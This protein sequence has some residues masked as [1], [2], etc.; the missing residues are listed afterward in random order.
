[1]ND[2]ATLPQTGPALLDAITTGMNPV[3]A[4][5]R[6]DDV[7]EHA[8]IEHADRACAALAI[9]LP[10]VVDITWDSTPEM[11]DEGQTYFTYSAARYRRDDGVIVAIQDVETSDTP[12]Y[13]VNHPLPRLVSESADE[14][15]EALTQIA[16]GE[17][18]ERHGELDVY[19]QVNALMTE[20]TGAA[21]AD[22]LKQALDIVWRAIY[23][24]PADEYNTR[25]LLQKS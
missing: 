3:D 17:D 21:S 9:L 23:A 25:L 6:I 19:D 18:A 20:F 2:T 12:V 13:S 11:G 1:M 22:Q 8:A 24:F 14:T 16:E 4:F 5:L 7:R 15:V 10:R